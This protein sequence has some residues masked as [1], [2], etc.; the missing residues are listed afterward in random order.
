MNNENQLPEMPKPATDNQ[1]TVNNNAQDPIVL[2]TT[3]QE[4]KKTNEA[5]QMFGDVKETTTKEVQNMSK[6]FK[7]IKE[8][9]TTK[10][11]S[12]LFALLWRLLIIAGFIIAAYLPFYIIIDFGSNLF[13]LFGIDYTTRLG[14]IWGSIWNLAYSVL[15]II[16]FFVLCKDRY[17]KLVKQQENEKKNEEENR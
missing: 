2:K 7:D 14:G 17:Y 4:E 8:Y 16:L 5:K 10:N 9:I 6:F 11:S 15:A 12:E 3:P 1:A 13:I